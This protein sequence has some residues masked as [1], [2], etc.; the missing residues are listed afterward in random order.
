MVLLNHSFDSNCS[1]S[2]PAFNLYQLEH[3]PTAKWTQKETQT[4]PISATRVIRHQDLDTRL[5]TMEL[6]INRIGTTTLTS[7]TRTTRP[8][9][10]PVVRGPRSESQHS[11]SHLKDIHKPGSKCL[12][13][14]FLSPF[15]L[16]QITAVIHIKSSYFI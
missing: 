6:A 12:L 14:M 4:A 10:R 13:E 3:F 16:I 8:I 7:A 5:A 1:N 2:T 11:Y 9:P 15:I